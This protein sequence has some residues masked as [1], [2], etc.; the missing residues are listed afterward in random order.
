MFTEEEYRTAI[1]EDGSE[2]NPDVKYA[3]PTNK[4]M[5]GDVKQLKGPGMICLS[6]ATVLCMKN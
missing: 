5:E 6:V 4:S 2:K 3:P 1:P